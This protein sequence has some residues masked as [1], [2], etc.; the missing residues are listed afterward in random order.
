MWENEKIGQFNVYLQYPGS[1]IPNQI[2]LFE[3]EQ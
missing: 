1:M 2:I 3:L